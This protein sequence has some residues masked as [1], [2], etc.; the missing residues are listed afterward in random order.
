MASDALIQ[1]CRHAYA[2]EELKN[3][4]SDEE[5]NL[6]RIQAEIEE[7]QKLEADLHLQLEQVQFEIGRFDL[8]DLDAARTQRE[9]ALTR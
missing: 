5:D 1:I 9:Q 3:H 7:K 4:I 2:G 8:S 6:K